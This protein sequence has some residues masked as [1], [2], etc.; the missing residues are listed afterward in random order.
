MQENSGFHDGT[1]V[2]STI[3]PDTVNLKFGKWAKI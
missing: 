2:L 3:F 1:L